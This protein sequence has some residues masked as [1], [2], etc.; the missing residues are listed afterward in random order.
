MSYSSSSSTL[1]CSLSNS[2]I[3]TTQTCYWILIRF[4]FLLFLNFRTPSVISRPYELIVLINNRIL[5]GDW[6]IGEFLGLILLLFVFLGCWVFKESKIKKMIWVLMKQ[7]RKKE[8]RLCG[9]G[10]FTGWSWLLIFT[11]WNIKKIK[12]FCLFDF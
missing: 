10:G 6:F 1:R 5:N 9:D 8:M 4:L 12:A 11:D 3:P 7:N 2:L